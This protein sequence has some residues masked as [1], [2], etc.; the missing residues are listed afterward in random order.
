MVAAKWLVGHSS[1]YVRIILYIVST[2]PDS[3]TTRH[4]VS[5]CRAIELHRME[6]VGVI[7]HV[8]M[9]LV[10]CIPDLDKKQHILFMVTSVK[11][12]MKKTQ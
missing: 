10:R 2:D 1:C 4:I 9:C 6:L 7:G 3:V 11:A 8:H 5:F 12:L